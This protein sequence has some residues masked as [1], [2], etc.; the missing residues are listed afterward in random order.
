MA[1]V[2]ELSVDAEFGALQENARSRAWTLDRVSPVAF[3]LG[4]P[5][6][7]GSWFWLKCVC[8]HYSAEP[9]AWHLYDPQSKQ[10][11]QQKDTPKPVGFFHSNGVICAPW[12]R[13]A[14]TSIDARGPH[15]DW[16]IGDWRGNSY[17][18]GCKTLSAMA[19]RIAHELRVNMRGR[20]AP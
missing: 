10:R 20:M 4:L 7:D 5:A 19:L 14:Y 16:S 13:L 2:A 11:D 3:V 8:D 17:T 12:N 1:T 9:P 18:G 15:A 6:S